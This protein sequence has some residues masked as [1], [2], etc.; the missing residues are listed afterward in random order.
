ME[1]FTGGNEEAIILDAG[2]VDLSLWSVV[3]LKSCEACMSCKVVVDEEV[4]IG[5]DSIDKASDSAA[6]I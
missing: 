5:L 2:D 1:S 4:V 3:I 6:P